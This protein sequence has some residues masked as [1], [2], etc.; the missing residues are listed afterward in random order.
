[1]LNQIL[2][3]L[4]K[5]KCLSQEQFSKILGIAQ[6][7]YAGYETGRYEPDLTTLIKIADFHKVSLDY[8]TGRIVISNNFNVA[9]FSNEYTAKFSRSPKN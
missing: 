5:E 2:R 6:T 3:K 8:L 1:M 9:E 7:T 4:R